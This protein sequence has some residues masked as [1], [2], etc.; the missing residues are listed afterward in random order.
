[1]KIE[2]GS[3]SEGNRD[4]S[5]SEGNSGDKEGSG[6]EGSAERWGGR[7]EIETPRGAGSLFSDEAHGQQLPTSDSDVDIHSYIELTFNIL[8]P[9]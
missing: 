9:W 4:G 2:W 3:G 7:R 6:S 8:D 5:G 1:V